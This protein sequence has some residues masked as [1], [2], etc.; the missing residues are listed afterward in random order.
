VQKRLAITNK[1]IKIFR[2]MNSFAKPNRI[3]QSF[4]AL[5]FTLLIALMVA[6]CSINPATGDRQFVALMSPA[7]EI[8]VGYEEHRKI[9]EAYG[10]RAEDDPLH[11]YVDNIGQ[12]LAVYTERPEI[13]YKFFVLDSPMVNAFALPGGYVYVTRGLLAQAN[14]E[15]ELAAV[16]AHEIAHIT[17]RHSAERY[18]HGVLTQLGAGILASTIDDSG[19]TQGIGIGSDLFMKSY[20]RH[21]EHQADA[22]GIR[23]LFRAEYS[24]FAM[25]DFL[26]NLEQHSALEHMIAGT[27]KQEGVANYFSTHPQTRDRIAEVVKIAQTYPYI[28]DVDSRTDYIRRLDGM[29]YGHSTREGFM[30]GHDFFHPQ[31]GFTFSVPPGFHVNNQPKRITAT[32]KQGT[33][34]IFDAKGVRP[35]TIPLNYM[36]QDWMQGEDVQNPSTLDINGMEAATAAFDGIVNNRPAIIRIMAVKW[37]HDTMFRFQIAI[38]QGATTDLLDEL[39]RTTYSLRRLTDKERQSLKAHQLKIIRAEPGDT[40][41]SIAK[42]MPYAD[43]QEVRFRVLNGLRAGE[44]VRAGQSYKMIVAGR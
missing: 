24:P 17:A 21:H 28:P 12:R 34:M 3:I 13:T 37:D 40:V 9:V 41:A 43:Y 15:A 1:A 8:R 7:E 11:I 2:M 23:Y 44:E 27:E 32:D 16:L 25:R 18:S 10:I 30:V 4:I 20:S 5:F 36:M 29:V 33:V 42:D 31:M 6:G 22:L 35:G 19:V 38:P 39:K 14:S 26:R